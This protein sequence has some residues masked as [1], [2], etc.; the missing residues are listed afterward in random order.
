MVKIQRRQVGHLIEHT[1][2]GKKSYL[3]AESV[4][5]I[6]TD[7][8]A[9]NR[10]EFDPDT[11]SYVQQKSWPHVKA[12]LMDAFKYY[13]PFLGQACTLREILDFELG[14]PEMQKTWQKEPAA[15][16]AKVLQFIEKLEEHPEWLAL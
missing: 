8:I 13:R 15:I 2:E 6:L 10:Y 3:L 12:Y 9:K 5:T 1:I 14:G 11:D 4:V 16:R 7:F